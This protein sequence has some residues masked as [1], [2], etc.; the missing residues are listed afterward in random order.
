MLLGALPIL[1]VAFALLYQLGMATL[2]GRQRGFWDSLEWASESFTTTG[3]GQLV[4]HRALDDGAPASAR[5][6]YA[7][8]LIA[9]GSDDE[10]AAFILAARQLGFS[11]PILALVEDPLHRRPMMLA[12]AT[13]VQLKVLKVTPAALGGRHPA[14]LHIRQRT[15]CSVVAVE[16]GEEV[17]VEFGPDFRFQSD[18]TVYVCGSSQAI[19]RFAEL[20]RHPAEAG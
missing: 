12:G 9:N 16:R 20:Y 4:P 13:A 11:G 15:G 5:L 10:N 2:E 1:V 6:G 14:D 17:L 18:D 7:R 3:Y 19:R 8:A